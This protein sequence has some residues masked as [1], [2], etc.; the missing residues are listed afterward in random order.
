[1]TLIEA[2]ETPEDA[3]MYMQSDNF[4]IL[5]GAM[6]LLPSSAQIEFSTNGG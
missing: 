2:W 4:A 5:R 1:L 3:D 6:K